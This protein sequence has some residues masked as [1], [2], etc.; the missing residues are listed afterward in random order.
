MFAQDHVPSRRNAFFMLGLMTG[1]IFVALPPSRA[2]A[3]TISASSAGYGLGV[4]VQ[5]LGLVHLQAGPLPTGA[6]GTA[7][8]AYTQ[9]KSTLNVNV[10][11]STP[12]VASGLVSA[13]AVNAT[14]NSNVDGLA[15][16]RTTQASG[17]V[18]GAGVHLN[19]LP[20]IGS[21]LSLLGVDGTLSSTASISGDVGMLT[22]HGSTTIESLL[23]NIGGIN[24]D[25][26]AF[27]GASIAPNTGV[28]LSLLGISNVS[29]ILNEQIVA[30][31]QSS[32]SVNAFH[33]SL[34]QA[35][36]V[37]GDVVLGHS[38]AMVTAVPAP[39]SVASA[40]SLGAMRLLARRK[41]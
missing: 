27:V 2:G 6:S 26:S 16:L 31:D 5:A 29:L 41:R 24:V 11:A 12:L 38:Q 4:D 21:G 23:L 19:T 20:I 15:G 7:P 18:V 35:G 40:L 9:N 37:T 36:L 22:A 32:I 17:G 14:A 34:N 13:A 33:L 1:A 28:N 25:L 8:V 39:S 10:S 30:P 3:A